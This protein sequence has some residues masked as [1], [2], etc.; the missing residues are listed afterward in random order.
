MPNYPQTGK[1][2][3]TF[4]NSVLWMDN[5]EIQISMDPNARISDKYKQS[6]V[7]IAKRK[8]FTLGE[9][10]NIT[11]EEMDICIRRR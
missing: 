9:D 6:A 8:A 3:L 10:K 1:L 11:D 2:P 5:F 7:L 4:P